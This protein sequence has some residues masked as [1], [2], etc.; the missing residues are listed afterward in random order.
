MGKFAGCTQPLNASLS[1]PVFCVDVGLSWV[2]YR[3]S[4]NEL[5]PRVV[6]IFRTSP[7]ITFLSFLWQLKLLR[8]LL[9]DGDFECVY[10]IRVVEL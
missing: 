9:R 6:H 8:L 10:F 4:S 7:F 3:S 1:V 5:L 2:H